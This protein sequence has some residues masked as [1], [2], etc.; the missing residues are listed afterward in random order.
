M[1]FNIK[2]YLKKFEGFLPPETRIKR[3]ISGI[4][5]EVI[6]VEIG[7]KSISI[8]GKSL[9]INAPSV[10]KSEIAMKQSKIMKRIHEHTFMQGF[11]KIQ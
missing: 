8:K 10:I 4:L 9:F 3:T 1:D 6:G 7:S 11:N 5:Q 2:D